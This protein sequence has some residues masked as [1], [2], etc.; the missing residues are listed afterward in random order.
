MP[1]ADHDEALAYTS[2]LPHLIAGILAA[3]SPQQWLPLVASGWRDTTR[4]A[5]GSPELWR[6]IVAEN[7]LPVLRALH[8][9]ATVL[10][11]WTE[12][13]ENQD[14]NELEKLL[15]AG[16]AIRDAVGS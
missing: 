11:H 10:H 14:D 12:T 2:H 15:A 3:Q 9:F 7:R 6:D 1:A 5:G 8:N 4:V 13:I 16:K